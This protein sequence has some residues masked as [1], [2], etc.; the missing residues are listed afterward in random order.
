MKLVCIGCSYQKQAASHT[1]ASNWAWKPPTAHKQE[2][3]THSLHRRK[4]CQRDPGR[5]QLDLTCALVYGKRDDD[6]NTLIHTQVTH[7]QTLAKK[8]QIENLYSLGSHAQIEHLSTNKLHTK[9]HAVL[10][11]QHTASLLLKLSLRR[12]MCLKFWKQTR[13]FD[14]SS[15]THWP[16]QFCPIKCSVREHVSCLYHIATVLPKRYMSKFLKETE[17]QYFLNDYIPCC[18][19][20]EW[21]FNTF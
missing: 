16:I 21:H 3:N 18:Q 10:I 17:R 8:Y 19:S 4:R 12:Y 5:W 15:R 7:R 13:S 9:Q 6:D 14:D 1:H 11:S 2:Q 20:R